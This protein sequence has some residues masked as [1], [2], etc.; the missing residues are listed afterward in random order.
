MLLFA[1]FFSAGILGLIAAQ[2]V[3]F[4]PILQIWILYYLGLVENGTLLHFLFI[5]NLFVYA[6]VEEL[7]K[8]F[9]VIFWWNKYHQLITRKL[10]F[11][12]IAGASGLAFFEKLLLI[13]LK[14]QSNGWG[15]IPPVA[16]VF[17]FLEAILLH[18]IITGLLYPF[19]KMADTK[20]SRVYLYVGLLVVATIHSLYNYNVIRSA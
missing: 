15:G 20:N 1:V 5:L 16:T 10:F 4:F 9:S 18:S 8:Y 6:L 7:V 13:T 19:I 11:C 14:I 2:I 3:A 12:L 17:L